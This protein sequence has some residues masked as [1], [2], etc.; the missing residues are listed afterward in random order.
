MDLPAQA[1][2]SGFAIT[3]NEKKG[4]ISMQDLNPASHLFTGVD[5]FYIDTL[6]F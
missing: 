5:F 3:R 2:R 6:S 4:H 1:K